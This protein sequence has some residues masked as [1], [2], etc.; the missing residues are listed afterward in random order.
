[1][2][3]KKKSSKS[4]RKTTKRRTSTRSKKT[5]LVSIEKRYTST[6]KPTLHKYPKKPAK[7]ATNATKKTYIEKFKDVREKNKRLLD[8]WQANVKEA[9][10]LNKEIYGG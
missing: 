1:M 9:N 3:A 8:Q 10:Q 7:S 4:K 5:S 2:A 6:A